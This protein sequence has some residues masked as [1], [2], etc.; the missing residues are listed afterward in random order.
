MKGLS[1][2]VG[3]E[4]SDPEEDD[5]NIDLHGPTL[6]L[7]ESSDVNRY[8]TSETFRIDTASSAESL[9]LEGYQN[10]LN[11][12]SHSYRYFHLLPSAT[13]ELPSAEVTDKVNQY[14]RMKLEK[15]FSLNRVIFT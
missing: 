13:K 2:L 1:S 7:E 5:N 9:T 12:S 4:D 15:G 10:S 8:A 6:L 14:M 11:S 3:Y